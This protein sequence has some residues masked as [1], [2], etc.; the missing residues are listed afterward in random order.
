[1]PLR[2]FSK[3]QMPYNARPLKSNFKRNG[4]LYP[5]AEP[6]YIKWSVTRYFWFEDFS[7]S[8]QLGLRKLTLRTDLMSIPQDLKLV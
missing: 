4:L 8:P 3:E 6:T 1:M 7:I 5:A 2:M